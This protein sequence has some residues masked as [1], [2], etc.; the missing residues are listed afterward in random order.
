[1]Q[2]YIGVVLYGSDRAKQRLQDDPAFR[3]FTARLA[4]RAGTKNA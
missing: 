2:H 3:Q 1:L 4:A